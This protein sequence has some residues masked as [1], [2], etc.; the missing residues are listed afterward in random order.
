[1]HT[2]STSATSASVIAAGSASLGG[3]DHSRAA[4]A[5]EGIG[6][7]RLHDADGL[8]DDYLFDTIFM[9]MISIII[10]I[11]IIMVIITIHIMI[12]I[13]IIIITI[14]SSIIISI[15]IIMCFRTS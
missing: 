7:I 8:H 15:I 1:M 14:R 4:H 3:G 13:M 10:I 12:L 2:A 11:V 9:M 5:P 6:R